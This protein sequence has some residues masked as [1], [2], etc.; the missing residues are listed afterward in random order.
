ML[1]RFSEYP[2]SFRGYTKGW[3]KVGDGI[4]AIEQ[5]SLVTV[6]VGDRRP[7][8]P[9]LTQGRVISVTAGFAV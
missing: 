4:A 3:P 7:A 8:D 5:N 9:G 2:R 6:D 1:S